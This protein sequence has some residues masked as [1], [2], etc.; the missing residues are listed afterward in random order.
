MSENVTALCFVDEMT[1]GALQPLSLVAE[2]AIALLR[3]VVWETAIA[4]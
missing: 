4:S 2:P 3:F 1:L